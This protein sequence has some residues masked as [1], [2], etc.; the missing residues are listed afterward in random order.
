MANE[1][2]NEMFDALLKGDPESIRASV[3]A[4][5]EAAYSVLVDL[6]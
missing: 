4:D 6:L 3:R 1:R 5:I 2:H